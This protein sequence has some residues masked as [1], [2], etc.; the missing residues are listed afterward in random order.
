[1]IK[2]ELILFDAGGPE[3]TA[4]TLAACRERAKE[5]GL[6]TVVVATSTGETVLQ[7]LDAFAGTQVGVVGVTLQAGCWQKYGG[8]DAAK[9][10]DAQAR[11]AQI[12]TGTRTLMGNVGS[13][14][15]ERLGA[16]PLVEIVAHTYYTF[17]QGMKVAVEVALMAADAGLLEDQEQVIAVAGTGSGADTAIVMKKVYSTNFFDLK[18]HELICMP[19]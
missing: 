4:V 11:G 8:P 7:A 10:A 14:L 12:I 9:V 13:A 19:R 18:I 6:G 16:L 3:H 2:R 5:L 1:M 17:S 15:R